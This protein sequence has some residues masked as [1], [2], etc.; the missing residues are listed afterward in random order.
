MKYHLK[1]IKI[2]T[3]IC[4]VIL[5][6]S[7]GSQTSDIIGIYTY[8]IKDYNGIGKWYMGR[9]I[10]SVMGFE[11]MEWLERPER[12][13]EENVST[14]IKNMNI[15]VE[16]TIAD[17]GAGSG[18]HTFRMAAKAQS[19]FIYA[20]D[21]QEEM[22]SEISSRINNGYLKNIAPIL[23]TETNINLTENSVDKILLVDV[24]HEFK[25][26][27]E[28][29]KSIKKVLR[30]NGKI[31]IV[32]YRGEDPRVPIKK[33]HKMTEKQV[34]KEMKAVGLK[35]KVNRENLPWQH[36][37]IFEIDKNFK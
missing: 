13:S 29:M 5:F 19:G 35:L 27:Y 8:Q 3:L 7:C 31:F 6:N 23:G 18:Y 34:V 16:D 14:L 11:G 37:L 30:P 20:I 21:I 32:E 4:T 17:I 12:E 25:Y 26:P 9:E 33:I 2:L 24:Y 15:N 10:A 22:L 1:A 28:M 36:C